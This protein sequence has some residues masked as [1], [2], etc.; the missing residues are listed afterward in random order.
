IILAQLAER[1]QALEKEADNFDK[2]SPADPAMRER[3][4]QILSAREFRQVQGPTEWELLK[5]RLDAWLE[6]IFKK[7]SPK[8]P[9]LDQ[10]GSVFVW[11][12]IAIASSILAVWLYRRSRQSIVDRPREVLSFLPSAKSWRAWLAEARVK[13]EMG[14]WR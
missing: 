10:A 14:E 2:H 13:G 12:M 6:K 11:L 4:N 9:D 1:V 5:Q 3:L 7:L 8:V